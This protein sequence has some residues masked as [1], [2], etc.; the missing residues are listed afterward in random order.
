MDLES[1]LN[2]DVWGM[3]YCLLDV[4]LGDIAS[5][6][7]SCIVGTATALSPRSTEITATPSF[8]QGMQLALLLLLSSVIICDLEIAKF[9]F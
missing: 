7:S 1:C 5:L 6:T 3:D 4:K 2:C 9:I 8:T